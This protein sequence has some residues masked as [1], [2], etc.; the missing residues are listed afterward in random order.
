MMID[1][2]KEMTEVYFD[3]S[4]TTA[5]SKPVA[6]LVIKIMTEDYG[7]PSSAHMK[8]VEAEQYLR[9]AREQIARTL[10]AKETE[11]YFTSGGTESDNWAIIGGAE[12]NKRAGM[13][14]ITTSVEHP[15]VLRSMQYLEDQGYRVTYLPVNERGQINLQDLKEAL[16]EET[17]LVSIMMVNNEMGAVQPVKEAAEIVK[18]YNSAILFHVDAVQA[19]GKMPIIPKQLGIDMMSVSGHKLHGPKGTGFLYVKEK[20]KLHPFILGGGQQRGMRSGTDNVPGAAGL[21]LAAKES[22]DHLEQNIETFKLLKKTLCDGFRKM[23]QVVIHS[24]ETEDGA[25]HIVNASFVGVR[26]EVLLHALEDRG[27][28]V[29]AGSACSTNRKLP[30]S[31]VLQQLHLPRPE[32]ESALRFS[33]SEYNTV[34]EVN[35][36]LEVIGTFLPVLRRYTRQ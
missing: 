3:N 27:I 17:I 10:R 31:P 33:F 23:D 8:G 24:S 30:V 21:A 36:A 11:I 15:A 16:C 1:R 9:T 4:A 14:L 13:H 5:V 28:Y 32:M 12:A 29:S 19:Y 6:D 22:Y 26:S 34:E 35:Y 20:T 25:P 2:K 7:N 18:Q